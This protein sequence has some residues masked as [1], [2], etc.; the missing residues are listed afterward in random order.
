PTYCVCGW[1]KP[2][3]HHGCEALRVTLVQLGN[4]GKASH[5][6]EQDGHLPLFSTQHEP[7]WGLCQL[8]DERG[9]KILAEGVADLAPLCLDAVVGIKGDDRSQAAPDEGGIPWVSQ[10]VPIS[11]GTPAPHPHSSDF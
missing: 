10:E 9:S 1:V 11:K 7:L 5:V 3:V 4:C 8:L 2:R 6:A